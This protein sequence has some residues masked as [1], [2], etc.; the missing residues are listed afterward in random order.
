M[1]VQ[2]QSFMHPYDV[3]EFMRNNGIHKENVIEIVYDNY[4]KQFVLFWEQ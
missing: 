3:S 4:M 1:R 2:Y